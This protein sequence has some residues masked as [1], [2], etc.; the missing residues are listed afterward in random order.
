MD[1]SL[2]D[3]VIEVE[4]EREGGR[5]EGEREGEGGQREKGGETDNSL[6]EMKTET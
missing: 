6:I 3:R 2:E 4:K 1:L 5:K